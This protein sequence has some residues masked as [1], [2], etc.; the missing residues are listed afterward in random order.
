MD[1]EGLTRT[2]IVL[3]D[4]GMPNV[5][6]YKNDTEFMASFDA[7]GLHYPCASGSLKGQGDV[8]KK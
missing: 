3:G 5:M 8:R 6:D 7:V 4:G 1:K 2:K